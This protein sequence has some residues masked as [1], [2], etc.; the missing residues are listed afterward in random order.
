MELQVT[1]LSGFREGPNTLQCSSLNLP[2]SHYT[3][4]GLQVTSEP[5]FL[6]ILP[7]HKTQEAKFSLEKISHGPA[8]VGL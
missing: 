8:G 3:F 7:Y 2:I 1:G 4:P 5:K 6:T